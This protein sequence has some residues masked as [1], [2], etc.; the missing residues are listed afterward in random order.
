MGKIL[1][2]EKSH[3]RRCLGNEESL[4]HRL[5]S[6]DQLKWFMFP[7]VPIPLKFWS[8]G[9]AELQGWTNPA[10]RLLQAFIF[11]PLL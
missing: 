5:V 1:I 8:A 11:A 4:P 7:G 9:R 3:M 10:Q 2:L 6:Q